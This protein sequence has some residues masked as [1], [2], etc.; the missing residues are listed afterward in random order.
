MPSVRKMIEYLGKHLVIEDKI[1]GADDDL[2]ELIAR[3]T[4]E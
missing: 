1:L 2:Y 3:S 4:H